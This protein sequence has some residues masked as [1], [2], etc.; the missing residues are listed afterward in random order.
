MILV[1]YLDS[2]E[3]LKYNYAEMI[4]YGNWLIWDTVYSYIS[5]S[6]LRNGKLNELKSD[7]FS[8]PF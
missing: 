2:D 8:L 3:L 5:E 7:V 6:G 4:K 1:I